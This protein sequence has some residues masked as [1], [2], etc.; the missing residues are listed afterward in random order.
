MLTT[1]ADVRV[2]GYLDKG[3]AGTSVPL[4]L[5]SSGLED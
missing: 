3:G 5:L 1:S 2:Q 4:A